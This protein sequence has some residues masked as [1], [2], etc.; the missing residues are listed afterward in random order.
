MDMEDLGRDGVMELWSYSTWLN[1]Y[2][3]PPNRAP[4][5]LLWMAI[6]VREQSNDCRSVYG[7]CHWHLK[8]ACCTVEEAIEWPHVGQK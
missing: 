5:Q 3:D 4:K 8:V 1:I 7:K 2:L 6:K